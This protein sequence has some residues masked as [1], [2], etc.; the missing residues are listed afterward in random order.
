[1]SIKS[2]LREV[3]RRYEGK[4]KAIVETMRR[5][6]HKG[7][8]AVENKIVQ[9]QL[10]G[11]TGAGRGL[12]V[13][14]GKALKSWVPRAFIYN[15]NEIRGM[16]GSSARYLRSHQFGLRITSPTGKKLAIP[17]HP[18]AKGVWPRDM[19]GMYLI[20]RKGKAPILVRDYR[21]KAA[22]V[23]G[24][25]RKIR[26][27]DIMYVLKSSV[28]MPKRLYILEHYRRHGAKIIGKVLIAEIMK[29]IKSKK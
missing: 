1:L 24:K 26:R 23:A 6:I 15:G 4:D 14:T 8:M 17:V 29:K 12:N 7:M 25:V 13:D 18:D 20:V 21:G 19:G 11:R 27:T 5:G 3:I 28:K 16:L 22:K 2:N 9:P 10:H